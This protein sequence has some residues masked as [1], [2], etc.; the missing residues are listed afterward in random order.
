MVAAARRGQAQRAW[1]RRFGMAWTPAIWLARHE[2]KDWIGW[3]VES[4]QRSTRSRTATKTSVQRRSWLC[5]VNATKRSGIRWRAAIQDALRT[6]CPPDGCRVLRTIGLILSSTRGFGCRAAC[7][8][9]CAA[10]RLVICRG[11]RRAGRNWTPSMSS[12]ICRW[13]ADRTGRAHDPRPL[14]IGVRGWISA[15]LRARW[16][17]ERWKHTGERR[18]PAYAQFDKR[19]A[20]PG[21][22]HHPDVWD[23]SSGSAFCW[24]STPVSPRRENTGRKT[25]R[26]LIICGQQKV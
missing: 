21:N 24:A 2:A 4:I 7:A 8:S 16:L 11:W 6:E 20:L 3:T 19:F 5:G 18:C 17:C 25:S 22:A 15:A 13:K 23:R 10:R 14:G 1:P 12:R 26:S 9:Q